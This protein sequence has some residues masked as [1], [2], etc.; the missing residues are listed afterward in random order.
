MDKKGGEKMK[1]KLLT[2]T[3]LLLL[4]FSITFAMCAPVKA[5]GNITISMNNFNDTILGYVVNGEMKNTGDTPVTNITVIVKAYDAANNFLNQTT[6]IYNLFS[7]S[8]SNP[9][10]LMPGAAAAFTG[11][12]SST[13]VDH[14]AATAAYIETTSLPQGLAITVSKTSGA[15]YSGS[16]EGTMRNT[17]TAK[18]DIVKI[19]AFFF[20]S[21]GKLLGS[22]ETSDVFGLDAGQT[23][24]YTA[25]I[26]GSGLG[27]NNVASYQVYAESFTGHGADTPYV[28][29]YVS[30]APT[31]STNPTPSPGQTVPEFSFASAFL[32]I[33]IV[34]MASLII[35]KKRQK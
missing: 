14:A 21:T 15:N 6:A 22:G 1:Q 24:D 10:V 16:V 20:D 8:N 28:A 7:N 23:K 3:L 29:Q 26:T 19:Y 30:S 2:I 4:L 11:I 35:C 31:S 34:S 13:N 9:L 33:L 25:T 5:A 27:S 12:I 17:G 32:I 18:A